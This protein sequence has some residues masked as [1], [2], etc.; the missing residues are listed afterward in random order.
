[1]FKKLV[2]NINLTRASLCLEKITTGNYKQK[3]KAYDKL[4]KIPITK[5]IGLRIIE[6]STKRYSDEFKD[7]NINSMLLLLLFNNFDKE[8]CDELNNIFDDL[9]EQ[10][11]LDFLFS[12]FR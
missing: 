8:F 1:M 9:E 3:V 4:K 7:M 2:E 11:K 5:E 12:R 10:T 6:I